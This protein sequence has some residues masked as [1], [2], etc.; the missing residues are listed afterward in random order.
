MMFVFVLCLSFLSSTIDTHAPTNHGLNPSFISKDFFIKR[1]F[2]S[3]FTDE[4]NY[5]AYLARWVPPR[6]IPT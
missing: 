5:G 6:E 2:V 4:S 3:I 1:D